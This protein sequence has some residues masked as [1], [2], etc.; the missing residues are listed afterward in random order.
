LIKN[1]NKVVKRIAYFLLIW[2]LHAFG[3][4]ASQAQN[5]VLT[6]D[7]YLAVVKKYHPVIASSDLI[8]ASAEVVQLKAR[9]MFDPGL[10]FDNDSKTIDGKNYYSY[11][12]YGLDMHTRSPITIRAGHDN[13]SGEF[14]NPEFTI[15]GISYVGIQ[16]PLLNGLLFDERRAALRQAKLIQTQSLLTRQAIINDLLLEAHEAYYRW[17]AAFGVY[18]TL[19]SFERDAR[20]RVEW[21]KLSQLNGDRAVADTIEA[22]AQWQ[23]FQIQVRDAQ[24]NWINEAFLLSAYLW[25]DKGEPYLL[26]DLYIPDTTLLSVPNEMNSAAEVAANPDLQLY[27]VKL[28]SLNIEQRLKRQYL[29]PKFDFKANALSRNTNFFGF[30]D[31]Y[32]LTDNYKIGV[33]IRYPVG[34]RA[35]RADL[36]ENKIKT[37]QTRLDQNRKTWDYQIKLRTYQNEWSQLRD[38]I[39]IT[40]SM[41]DNNRTLRNFEVLKFNQGESSLFLVNSRENKVVESQLKGISLIEKILKTSAKINWITGSWL[42]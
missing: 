42:E 2:I 1:P 27:T 7:E 11:Q 32:L 19:Q 41:I 36:R 10:Y 26:D 35:A 18:R 33:S 34:A 22:A 30:A 28:N 3:S 31:S 9:A 16:V 39:R 13:A 8:V 37:E 24:M 12:N 29:L 5:Q 40:E 6:L 17:L 21:T 38:Q 25:S 15:G 20:Q 23:G 14:T 4:S